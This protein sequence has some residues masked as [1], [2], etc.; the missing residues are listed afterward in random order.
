MALDP[1]RSA[2]PSR[3]SGIS[4][5]CNA[6]ARVKALR[7]LKQDHLL[8]KG[9]L[10]DFERLYCTEDLEACDSLVKLVCAELRLHARLEDEVFY[11][12]MLAQGDPAGIVDKADVEHELVEHL[13]TQLLKMRPGNPRYVATFRVL[14][15]CARWHMREEETVMFRKLA[16]ASMDWTPLL[17]EMLEMQQ[18]LRRP[19]V[20][21]PQPRPIASRGEPAPAAARAGKSRLAEP[22]DERG[23][24]LETELG[25]APFEV[26]RE[27]S[28]AGPRAL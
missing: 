26:R 23:E 11:P 8:I 6:R 14:A 9:Y 3:S 1:V 16:R 20:Q 12:A 7:I 4:K 15:Q 10:R 24:E 27:L 21:R 28:V 19:V 18:E 25:V 2:R 22:G 17:E 13:I 5:N